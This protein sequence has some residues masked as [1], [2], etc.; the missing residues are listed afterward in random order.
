MA[1]RSPLDRELAE[2]LAGLDRAGET[3]RA[4]VLAGL[5]GVTSRGRRARVVR[6]RTFLTGAALALAAIP[7]AS[8]V[9]LGQL[10]N[11]PQQSPATSPDA[12]LG[13]Y[14]ADVAADPA[15]TTGF[16]GRWTLDLHGDGT[17]DVLPPKGY[18]GISTGF[19]YSTAGVQVRVD[20]FAQDLCTGKTIGTY[21]W[22]RDADGLQLTTINDSCSGRVALL[23]GRT[24]M[25]GP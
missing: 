11:E 9:V 5:V 12:I 14:S 25:P 21:T 16:A 7:L 24:W 10:R 6:R 18:T 2:R 8:V 13:T 22:H 4:D 20:L 15:G 17:L 3:G 23:A 19:H 1:E